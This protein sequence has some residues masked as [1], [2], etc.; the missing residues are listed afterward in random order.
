MATKQFIKSNQ[1]HLPHGNNDTNAVAK[2]SQ[3]CKIIGAAGLSTQ[4][5]QAK[6]QL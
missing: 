5:Q 1:T 2:M 4:Q 3:N 6:L